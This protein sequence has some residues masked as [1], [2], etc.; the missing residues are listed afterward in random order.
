M[1]ENNQINYDANLLQFLLTSMAEEESVQRFIQLLD[2]QNLSSPDYSGDTK[3]LYSPP[4]L[5][6]NG[7]YVI[8]NNHTTNMTQNVFNNVDGSALG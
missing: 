6:A 5:E 3:T 1:L 2:K 8:L 4:D 7:P